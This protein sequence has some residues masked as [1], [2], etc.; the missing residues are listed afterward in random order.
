MKKKEKKVR[1]FFDFGFSKLLSV[2]FLIFL[3]TCTSLFA[4]G[5]YLTDNPSDP[6]S[7]ERVVSAK[8]VGQPQGKV[9][10]GMV[11]DDKGIPLPG[12]TV[13]VDGATRGVITD[14]DGGFNIEVLPTD[15]LIFSFIGLESQKIEVG[16]QKVINVKL[17]QKV[18]ELEE[19]TVVAFAKQKKESVLS[20]ITTVKPSELKV[21]SSNLTTALAGRIAGLI[22]YQRSGEPGQ[23]NAEFFIRGVTSFGYASS[24][25]IL[26]DGLEMASS[27]LARMQP[28]DIASFSIMKDA[29][30][31]A[32]Y[33][34]RGANGVILVTTK[35]GKEGKAKISV[36]FETAVSA[37]TMQLEL[38]DPVTYMNLHNEAVVTRDPL[39]I[40]PYNQEKIAMT[41]AG[42]NPLIY[43]AVDW[44]DMLF[45]NS[46]V[47][48]RLNFN[49]SGGGKVARYYVAGTVNQDNGML[50]I[51]NRNNFNNNIDLKRYLIHSNVNIN[52]TNTT[53]M[54][55]R[56]HAS[57]DDYTGPIDG[58]STLYNKVMRTSPVLYPAVYPPDDAHQYTQHTLF[59]NYGAGNYINPY[60]DM[61]KGYK[62]YSQST[63]TAQFEL[64]QDLGFILDGLNVRGLFST[65][66]SSY[67]DVNRFYNPFYYS[68]AS[69]NKLENTYVLDVLN[70]TVG[71]EFLNYSEGTKTVFST[72]YAE[73]AL[74]YGKNFGE[75]HDVSAMLV[76]TMRNR[77]AANAGTLQ[78]S[79]PFR[80]LGLAGRTT[81]SYSKRYFLEANFGYN[82]SERFAKNHRFGFFPSVGTGW[83]L[84]NEEFYGE[85]IKRIIPKLKFKATYGLV[86]NDQIGSANDRFFFLS[87]VNMNNAARGA[88]FGSEFGYSRNGVSISRYENQ[89][90]AWEIA[91]KT[92]L[93]LEMSLLKGFEINVDVYK[94][95]RKNILMN[96]AYIPHSMGLQATPRANLGEASGKGIDFSVDYQKNFQNGVWMTGRVNF[97]YATSKYKVY[98]EPDYS[99]TPW[100]SRVGSSLGQVWGYVAERLFVDESEV[101]NSPYQGL[102]VMAGDI[103]YK[104]INGDGQISGLDQVPIG[105]PTTPEIVYGF[106]FSTGY[107]GVDFSC[108]F[109]G[110]AREAFWIDTYNTAP[111]IDTDGTSSS[112]SQN[113]LLQ[114]YADDHWSEYDRNVFAL[115]PRLSNEINANNRALST[116]FMRDG[117]FLRLKSA[118]V[119]YTI[120]L[121]LT[122]RIGVTKTRLYVSGTNLLTFSA[123]KLWDPEM[124]GNGSGYPIQRVINFG[125]QVSF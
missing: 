46:T 55:V 50:K 40:Q 33:G 98:E 48:N 96:R 93:G 69:F 84:S 43:P 118:E 39:G 38:A 61:V 97:T 83:I 36:R 103:K 77:S 100:K 45:K 37:P 14:K 66:R 94:E 52:I 31:T 106:G 91:A 125:L 124:A 68:V 15:K 54:I 9:L 89:N 71:T 111:F 102:E 72:T 30:A 41:L 119:G 56:L 29:T 87:E 49:V 44:H 104:D 42:N 16:N 57:F 113:A 58:G 10:K 13:V 123:F 90:I 79:L 25:L 82:G 78:E 114:V 105:Y 112:I 20:S 64:K 65:N 3:I 81:Y 70:P 60:A 8:S 80:N 75:K 109:Q 121:K 122:E 108:F 22:S 34:A 76:G 115:W 51:D 120:P 12:C 101:A 2:L 59:G 117:S 35:E 21:P 4:N 63:I 27:D 86:G 92:N 110:V 24:P 19:V 7:P 26:I 99:A 74:S 53:E 73:A 28:D 85:A 107:K 1:D 47:N 32:L 62:D 95:H 67:F 11:T 17:N 5:E 23:D 6:I 88:T 18:D 116:W